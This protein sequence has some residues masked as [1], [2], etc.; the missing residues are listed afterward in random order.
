MNTVSLQA[1][2]K[3]HDVRSQGPQPIAAVM[4]EV[5]AR[6]GLPSARQ[7]SERVAGYRTNYPVQHAELA[8]A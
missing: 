8:V 2:P 4:S 1:K 7:P 3:D 5:L 6:Y